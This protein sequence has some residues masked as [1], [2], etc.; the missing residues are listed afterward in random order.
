M[1]DTTDRV[2]NGVMRARCPYCGASVAFQPDSPRSVGVELVRCDDAQDGGC[3]S[4][5]VAKYVLTATV[6]AAELPFGED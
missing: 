1:T 3:D 5:F 6:T 4:L 2:Y